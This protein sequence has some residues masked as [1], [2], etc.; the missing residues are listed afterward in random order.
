[1]K[2]LIAAII[3][4]CTFGISAYA[5]PAKIETAAEIKIL[6][7]LC[8]LTIISAVCPLVAFNISAGEIS[9]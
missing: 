5:E 1:M 9:I 8:Y 3:C 4:L 7:L 6:L 2:R